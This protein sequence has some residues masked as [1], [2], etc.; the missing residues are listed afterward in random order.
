MIS[1][2]YS[3]TKSPREAPGVVRAKKCL[4]PVRKYF[5]AERSRAGE[6]GFT[7]T[8]LM[9]VVTVISI[10]AVV[11]FI[12]IRNDQWEGAY[13]RFTDDLVGSVIQARN[14]AIDDQTEVR[15]EIQSDRLEVYWTDPETKDEVLLWGNYR[16]KIDGGL[17]GTQ[18]CITGMAPGISAPSESNDAAMP[19]N[20]LGGIQSLTFMPDGSFVDP[21]NPLDDAGMTMV[22]MNASSASANYSIIEM[23]PGGLIRKF[24]EIPAP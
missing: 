6:R 9:I 11:A 23:F 2:I 5:I 19:V 16:D 13:Y 8:E 17:L 20:C 7:L 24:D 18:A 12:G 1:S 10:V 15:I 4:R 14:R 3:S 22:I 21:D